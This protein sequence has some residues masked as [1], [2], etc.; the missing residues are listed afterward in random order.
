MQLFVML[1]RVGA[2]DIAN[3]RRHH[4]GVFTI[5]QAECAL[6]TDLVLDESRRQRQ[7]VALCLW[8]VDSE[9]PCFILA[10]FGVESAGILSQVDVISSV[11]GGSIIAAHLAERIPTWPEPGA[12]VANWDQVVAASFRSFVRR[13]RRTGPVFRR[14]IP[15]NWRSPGTAIEGLAAIFQR[16]LTS[17]KLSE[18]PVRLRF[19]FSA[20]DMGVWHVLD[21]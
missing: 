5:D 16:Q 8:E 9:P 17:L 19:V 13:N 4:V 14:L 10:R 6:T 11:S 21:L 18:L 15:T 1:Y 2:T 20:T 12:V 3:H 7:G